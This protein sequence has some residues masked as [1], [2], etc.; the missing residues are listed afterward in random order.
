[1]QRKKRANPWLTLLL[2]G[3]VGLVYSG[4]S[5]SLSAWDGI[6]WDGDPALFFW[7]TLP[8]VLVLWGLWLVTGLSWLSSLL[9]G[10][11]VFF[12]TGGNYFK[13]EFRSTPL[14]WQDLH[15]LRE[16]AQMA[17]EYEVELTPLMYGF[18]AAIFVC[19]LVL[20]LFGGGRPRFL[21][22]LLA[23]V[24]VG[25]VCL[26]CFFRVYPDDERYMTFAGE[27]ARS[28]S[29]GYAACG[30]VYPFLHSYGDYAKQY[31]SYDEET[32]Q[33]IL[34]EYRDANIPEDQKVS[35]VTIQLEA[36]ADLS[37]YDV[38]G[39]APSVYE[40][41]H[42][43]LD[44]SYSG[45]L[46]V[47]IFAGGTAETEWAVLT[48]GNYH[49]DFATKTNSVAWYLKK[50]GY[51]T[52]GG[53]PSRDWFYNRGSVNPNLGLD[54]Y[55]FMDNYYEDFPKADKDVAYDNVFFPDL[56][57]RLKAHFES[58][59]QPVFSFNVTY[60][61]HGPY[62]T[63]RTY[64]GDHY[65]TGDYDEATRNVLN[66]YFY[67]I[68]DTSR[69]LRHLQDFL[70]SRE[71]PVVLLLYGDH[72]PWMGYNGSIYETLGASLD[73]STEKGF[74]DYYSTWYAVWGNQAA[75]ETLGQ[76]F[77]G[78]GPDL[79]PCF[80]M[81]EVFALCGWEGSAYMQAQREVARALP[82]LHT[83]GW[84]KEHGAY[85]LT[86]TA[87]GQALAQQFQLVSRY[88]RTHYTP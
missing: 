29:K 51:V 61:G 65:C 42:A 79:S 5:L 26:V 17:G 8:V 7:N 40:D 19:T 25:A 57:K 76:A 55:L 59:S 83:S 33:A 68:E 9:V 80:L 66:N 13:L 46:V 45:R 56:E 63:E 72:K 73:T 14:L 28:A 15:N 11:A 74:L 60:Q 20:A 27:Y 62:N 84:V 67:F 16:G 78:A 50:Q 22:R 77:Q 81:D 21:L 24:V 6:S 82:V 86:P 70:D 37:L 36:F 43:L 23:L 47:D 52:G 3:V 41:F 64:W 53:H 38:D 58:S 49:D 12:M 10:A 32:A 87:E 18:L 31:G 30:L 4:F 69:Y 34:E 88:D 39:L 1:M 35:L 2:L 54:D 85:T 71:E 44:E 48:G 75:K